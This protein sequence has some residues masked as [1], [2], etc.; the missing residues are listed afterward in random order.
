MNATLTEIRYALLQSNGCGASPG[1]AIP[2]ASFTHEMSCSVETFFNTSFN[3][4]SA[5]WDF[6][7][8]GIY[9]MIGDT[10]IYNYPSSGTYTIKMRVTGFGGGDSTSQTSYIQ[11]RIQ[12][13]YPIIHHTGYSYSPYTAKNYSCIGNPITVYGWPSM[14]SY[15]WSN[16]ETTQNISFIADSSF[17]LSLTVVDMEGYTWTSCPEPIHVDIAP[18]LTKPIIFSDEDSIC[19]SDSLHFH[20]LMGENQYVNSWTFNYAE[21]FSTDL[22]FNTQGTSWDDFIYLTIRDVNGC[23][24]NSDTSFIHADSSLNQPYIMN[25]IGTTL[26]ANANC[27]NQFY[28]DGAPIENAIDNQYLV[29]QP[30][31]Y[32]VLS[33]YHYPNCAVMSD[34]V[35][36]TVTAINEF[37]SNM[38]LYV[39]P[40]PAKDYI[41]IQ[42]MRKENTSFSL[43]NTLGQLVVKEDLNTNSSFNQ[44][45][46][47]ILSNGIYFWKIDSNSETTNTGKLFIAK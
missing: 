43:Y 19:V 13:S 36:F 25:Q 46:L 15:L 6:E 18:A 14:A 31:C 24:I 44:I 47:K 11:D 39:F 30:G 38:N 8:D 17:D 40:N 26:Y 20:A 29:D 2:S 21:Y 10:V 5:E 35:C 3:S 16:G 32:S 9:D 27:S 45:P 22:Q 1:G 12:A 33:W 23:K 37:E 42:G 7:N 28:K 34:T 4:L 41:T